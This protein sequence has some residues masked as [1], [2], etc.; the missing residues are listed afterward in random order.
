MGISCLLRHMKAG[1]IH[2]DIVEERLKI[3]RKSEPNDELFKKDATN[4]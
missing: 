2:D 3:S 4:L 1:T